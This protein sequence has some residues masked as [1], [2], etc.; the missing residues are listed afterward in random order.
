MTEQRLPRA[1][2]APP[3]G[4]EGTDAAAASHHDAI[5]RSQQTEV[6]ALESQ[7]RRA[8]ADVDNLRKRM[9][10][11]IARQRA[12]ERADVAARWLPVVDNLE[13]A[14]EH[15]GSD[16]DAVLEGVRAVRDQALDILAALGFP[17]FDEV[18]RPFDPARDEAVSAMAADAPP[19][20]VVAVV[21]PGYGTTETVLRPAG[22]IVSKGTD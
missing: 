16:A 18:G 15:A 13:R 17:R 12:N 22:V 9:D 5:E 21:R 8:L 11:E 7:L 19:G 20:T 4:E 14:L 10:R 6:A 3:E 1:N 2:E